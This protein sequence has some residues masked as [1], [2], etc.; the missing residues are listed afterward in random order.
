[1]GSIAYIGMIHEPGLRSFLL[2]SFRRVRALAWSRDREMV[3]GYFVLWKGEYTSFSCLDVLMW[4]EL[5]LNLTGYTHTHQPL[6]N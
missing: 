4:L 5:D 3:T 1:M 6:R 2:F